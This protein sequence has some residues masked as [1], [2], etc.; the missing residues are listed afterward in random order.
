[1]VDDQIQV[2]EIVTKFDSD[3]YNNSYNNSYRLMDHCMM[4]GQVQGSS[5]E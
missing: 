2:D 1:M 3:S 4:H 5:K